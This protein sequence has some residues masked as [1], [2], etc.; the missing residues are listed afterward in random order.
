MPKVRRI[1][2]FRSIANLKSEKVGFVARLMGKQTTEAKAAKWLLSDDGKKALKYAKQSDQYKSPQTKDDQLFKTNIDNLATLRAARIREKR[3]KQ[4]FFIVCMILLIVDLSFFMGTLTAA[5]LSGQ[6][7]ISLVSTLPGI[8]TVAIGALGALGVA[9]L[10]GFALPW[11]NRA[12]SN[13]IN[14]IL[15][16]PKWLLGYSNKDSELKV[17][18]T[19][20]EMRGSNYQQGKQDEVTLKSSW[21]ESSRNQVIGSAVIQACKVVAQTQRVNKTP[22]IG[23]TGKK[24][25]VPG[26]DKKISN[27]ERVATFSGSLKDKDDGK[28]PKL[29]SGRSRRKS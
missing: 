6:L 2:T 23:G 11:L 21:L 10:V 26:F 12:I 29:S 17:A 19:V 20:A 1:H 9:N 24:S 3:L 5:Y 27:R 22:Q 18:L 28:T 14:G 25:F 16:L 13:I 8:S 15:F 7:A 4:A